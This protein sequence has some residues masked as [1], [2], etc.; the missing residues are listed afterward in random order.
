MRHVGKHVECQADTTSKR[1]YRCQEYNAGVNSNWLNIKANYC[2]VIDLKRYRDSE[3]NTYVDSKALN[4]DQKS[5]GRCMLET[6]LQAQQLG[7]GS[8]GT[9]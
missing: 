5:A 9:T 4:P 3:L 8:A 1:C 7:I 2:R 6:L